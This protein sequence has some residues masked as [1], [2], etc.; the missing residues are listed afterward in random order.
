MTGASPD[1]EETTTVEV[2]EAYLEE[3]ERFRRRLDGAMLAGDVAW[4]EMDVETGA[5]E[6]HD[7]KVEML[8]MSPADFAHYEDFTER[9]HPD[10]YET[11]MEAMRAHLEGRTDRYDT[12]YRI[13]AAD[14]E[15][16]WFHD[17]GGITRRAADGTP[18]EVTGIVID[19][20]RRK[21]AEERLRRTNE[22]LALLNTVVRHDIR[23]DMTVASGWLD[24]LEESV[25]GEEQDAVRRARRATEHTARLTETVRDLMTVIEDGAADVTLEPVDAVATLD[26]EIDR[27]RDTFD[28]VDIHQEYEAASVSVEANAMLSTVFGNI[29]TNAVQHSDGDDVRIDVT[30]T[31][32]DDRVRVRIADDGPGIPESIR[33]T[34]F[35]QGASGPE[36]MGSGVGLYLVKTLVDSYGGTIRVTDADP[37]GAVVTIDLVPAESAETEPAR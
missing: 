23:N 8:G 5:V 6:F 9:V 35:E 3:L 28:G 13:R 21:E 30:V 10:D 37:T 12:E 7:N 27:V 14:G 16:E 31:T 17:V 32:H 20:S 36:S 34:L 11:A 29:L 19:I 33:E 26:R 25:S 15:Y 18:L 22:Q 2:E 1:S 24:I 4:W